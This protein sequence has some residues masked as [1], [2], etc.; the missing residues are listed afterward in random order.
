ML[1]KNT[2]QYNAPL[3]LRLN[4]YVIHT[5]RSGA[6]PHAVEAVESELCA[7]GFIGKRN[8]TLAQ[9]FEHHMDS[10]SHTPDEYTVHGQVFQHSSIPI[11]TGETQASLRAGSEVNMGKER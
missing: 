7:N 10:K 8:Q 9:A 1:T 4:L 3:I 5:L 2:Y 6:D 11:S